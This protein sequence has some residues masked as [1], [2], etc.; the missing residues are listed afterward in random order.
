M[1]SLLLIKILLF[2]IPCTFIVY[3]PRLNKFEPQYLRKELIE[4]CPELKWIRFFYLPVYIFFFLLVFVSSMI[5]VA[6]SGDHV[7]IRTILAIYTL[8]PAIGLF[9]SLFALITKVRPI[10]YK[11]GGYIKQAATDL[12]WVFRFI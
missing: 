1:N 5:Y 6:S 11:T 3:L 7:D 8:I 12:L 10:P 9:D 2:V 4:L